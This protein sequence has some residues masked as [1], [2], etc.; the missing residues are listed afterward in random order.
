M[1]WGY[2]SAS[3]WILSVF[4]LNIIASSTQLRTKDS[5]CQARSERTSKETPKP[6]TDC[7]R[8]KFMLKIKELCP[9]K[10]SQRQ[11]KTTS[12]TTTT[13]AF[14]PRG[15]RLMD[16]PMGTGNGFER[17]A[18]ECVPDILKWGNKWA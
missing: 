8:A 14:G 15:R 13:A 2:L 17:R 1:R 18:P 3:F 11:R 4:A 6:S 5:C 12:S 10:Q 9:A 16:S 7:E